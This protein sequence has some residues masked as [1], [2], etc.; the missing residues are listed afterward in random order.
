MTNSIIADGPPYLLPKKLRTPRNEVFFL[1]YIKDYDT[2]RPFLQLLSYGCYH[3]VFVGKKLHLSA[4]T[5]DQHWARVRFFLPE[6]RLHV[7]RRGHQEIHSLQ[8]D[9]YQAS[10]NY[11]ARTYELHAVTGK[12]AFYFLALLSA[13]QHT[14]SPLDENTITSH[15]LAPINKPLPKGIASVSRSSVH[16]HL[17][18][19]SDL[20][21]IA[22]TQQGGHTSYLAVPCD[23]LSTLDSAELEELCSAIRAYRTFSHLAAPGYLLEPTLCQHS[24]A[25]GAAAP[26]LQLKHIAPARILDDAV[27][28]ALLYCI[29]HRC[30]CTFVYRNENFLRH[31]LP[32]RL[33]TDFHT[34]RQ[35]LEALAPRNKAAVYTLSQRYRLDQIAK[36]SVGSKIPVPKK[37]PSP[38]REPAPL[39]LLFHPKDKK[40][41]AHI[42]YRLRQRFPSEREL[43]L[44]CRD[45]GVLR[46]TLRLKDAPALVPWLRTFFP[47]LEI[48]TS[49]DKHAQLLRR[50]MIDDLEEA[51]AN[52][53]SRIYPPVP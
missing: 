22:C 30:A 48:P 51:L 40:D 25:C 5:Y 39:T 2:W 9:S 28:D 38:T 33:L 16:R 49:Q 52:Y 34:G 19:L 36:V 31:A 13:L 7:T 20:G 44:S 1:Y 29:E 47:I 27:A 11:L 18:E 23:P 4:R 43:T 14:E 26:I 3:K 17:K 12:K 15:V 24:P 8:G 35:Y 53:E 6:D 45:D 42:R 32:Q 21:L 37:T 10:L 50:K 41:A 46:A